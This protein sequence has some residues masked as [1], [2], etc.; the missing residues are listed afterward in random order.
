MN[1]TRA[2]HTYKVVQQYHRCQ[3]CGH[4]F[5]SRQDFQYCMG[6]YV[7]QLECPCCKHSFQE[8]KGARKALGPLLGEMRCNPEDLLND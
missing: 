4:I 6:E 3:D 5:E 8:V 2:T 7:K 1:S